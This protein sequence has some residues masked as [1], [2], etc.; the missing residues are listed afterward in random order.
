MAPK[1][2]STFSPADTRALETAYQKKLEEIEAERAANKSTL[3]LRAGSKRPRVVSADYATAADKEK[4]GEAPESVKVPVNE[5]YL[6]DV[7]I[8]ERELSPVYWEGPVY[9]VRRGTWFYQEGSTLRPCEENLAAQL[10]EGYLKVKPWTYPSRAR[11]DSAPK[12]VTPKASVEN[13]KAA[14]AAQADSTA[15]PTVSTTQHQPQ[16]Q[17]LFGAHLNSIVTYQDSSVAWLSSEGVLSWVTSTVYERFAGGGYMSGIKLV[18]GYTEA[19]KAKEEKR[20]L[21]PSGTQSIFAEQDEK[22]QKALKRRSAPAMSQPQPVEEVEDDDPLELEDT[23]RRL[24]RQFSN[25]LEGKE[26]SEEDQEAIRK[27]EE[28]DMLDDYNFRLGEKQGREIEH[29][30]LITHGIGQLLSLKYALTLSPIPRW[31]MCFRSYADDTRM[32]SINFVHDVNV[33]RKS[34][35]SVYSTSADLRSLNQ[36]AHEGGPGNCRVQVLPVVWRHLLDFPKRRQKKGEHDLGDSHN[37]E[38]ECR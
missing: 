32:E 25:L 2:F 1:K 28:K 30:V 21:T 29:V 14:A 18:R 7:N 4:P 17:R 35:K 10:E 16:T 36:E 31:D 34:L 9:E 33:L 19:S 12:T 6:F 27:Q 24:T 3:V 20:P 15:K 38:D 5:D 37:E 13:L 8:G 23:T 22:L 11:S 26:D